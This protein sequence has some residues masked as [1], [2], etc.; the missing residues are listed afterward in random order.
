MRDFVRTKTEPLIQFWRRYEHHLGVGALTFG[1]IFDLF[2]AKKPDSVFDNILLCSYL[3][4]AG[5]VI[6][7]LNIRAR[8]RESQEDAAPLFMLLMLQFCFGGLA[9]N[10]LVLYGKSGTLAGSAL[11]IGMLVCLVF[12][13]EY[14]RNRYSQ[15]RFNIVVYYFLL[16]TYSIISVPTFIFHAIGTGVF[17]ASGLISLAVIAV[18]LGILYFAV[19]RGDKRR[20]LKEIGLMVGI[21]FVIFNGLYFLNIIPPVPLSLKD[22]GVYHSILK[23]SS[24]DYLALYEP[25]PWYVF[26]RDTS[27]S[28]TFAAGSSAYCFSSVYA[29]ADLSAPIY[30]HWEHFNAATNNWDTVSR[31]SFPISGGRQDGYRGFSA[32]AA[33][34]PG[35]WRC[36]VETSSGA[37]IGRF[38][39]TAIESSTTLQLSQATL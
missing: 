21:V 2:V 31:I 1:F 17:L 35:K 39:F 8:R 29:P 3:F 25:A 28:F 26:W 37:L 14:L 16:L 36:N 23:Y 33:L 22:I 30:H 4:I 18:F 10:L 6:I 13:N 20:Q 11:F 19:L 9:S 34:A 15:L 5:A 12:G 24:G 7:L 27:T 32:T 38:E